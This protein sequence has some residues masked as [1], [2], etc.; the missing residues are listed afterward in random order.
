M[1]M[2]S[3]TEEWRTAHPG[4]RIG[5]LELSGVGNARPASKLDR[6]KRE[7][8][9]DLRARYEGFSRRDF[10]ALPVMAAYAL[11]Y[12]RFDKTYHVQLQVESIVLKGKTLPD[13]SPLVDANFV[14]EVQPEVQPDVQLE[15]ADQSSAPISTT[16]ITI[17]AAVLILAILAFAIS[18]RRKSV[19]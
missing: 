4:A 19:N 7:A 10:L 5:L 11:Y 3:A 14:A 1:L 17:A 16:A 13:V 15:A 12:K 2:I 8:E 6:R 18:R 9:A